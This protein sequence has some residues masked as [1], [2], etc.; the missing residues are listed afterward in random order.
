MNENLIAALTLLGTLG[1]YVAATAGVIY[2]AWWL[3]QAG[4]WLYTAAVRRF[5][6]WV[7]S[8]TAYGWDGWP[9]D[10]L[11]QHPDAETLYRRS[12]AEAARLGD[13]QNLLRF[14]QIAADLRRLERH[15][16]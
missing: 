13:Y 3:L 7:D 10:L 9:K 4:H 1:L 8:P 15:G 11:D 12:V 2:G 14:W 6:K 16:R 5:D